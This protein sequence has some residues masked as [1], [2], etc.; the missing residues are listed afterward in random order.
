MTGLR[1]FQD[2]ASGDVNSAINSGSEDYSSSD[3]LRRRKPGVATLRLSAAATSQGSLRFSQEGRK[4]KRDY[5]SAVEDD[6]TL[7]GSLTKSLDI[8][9]R[10]KMLTRSRNSP[11]SVRSSHQSARYS[12]D[13][14]DADDGKSDQRGSLQYTRDSLSIR[15][16]DE[17]IDSNLGK[18]VGRSSVSSSRPRYDGND[19]DSGDEDTRSAFDLSQEDEKNHYFGDTNI[20]SAGTYTS[21]LSHDND[22]LDLNQTIMTDISGPGDVEERANAYERS[23]RETIKQAPS[24]PQNASSASNRPVFTASSRGTASP[25]DTMTSDFDDDGSLELSQSND[26][27]G[28][29]AEPPRSSRFREEK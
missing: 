7:T 10:P 23:A 1:S 28:N 6:L 8:Q 19:G 5:D 26:M 9:S 3:G 21:D 27:F 20:H 13:E 29:F 25:F 24:T 22:N 17:T 16:F 18:S 12:S 2:T 15:G 4:K 14:D 11:P